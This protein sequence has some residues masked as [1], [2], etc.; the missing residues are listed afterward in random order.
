MLC[1][2][3]HLFHI[4]FGHFLG[5]YRKLFGSIWADKV[6]RLAFGGRSLFVDRAILG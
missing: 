5:H 3:G 4:D 6:P 1:K 2:D